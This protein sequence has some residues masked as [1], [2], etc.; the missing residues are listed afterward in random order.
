M[1]LLTTNQRRLLILNGIAAQ[2]DAQFDPFPVVKLTAPWN[3]TVW[4]LTE[5]APDDPDRLFGL[6][7]IHD[8]SP[9]L[10]YFRI[11]SLES[12]SGPD[13]ERVISDETF[14]A[15]RPCPPISRRLSIETIHPR[16]KRD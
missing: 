13:G 16:H 1:S 14:L 2:R 12:L 5:I 7:T 10:A 15:D 9:E 11:G 4:L 6:K 8:G 3:G